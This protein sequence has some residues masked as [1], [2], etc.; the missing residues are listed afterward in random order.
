[1]G[2]S[3]ARVSSSAIHIFLERLALCTNSLIVD[4]LSEVVCECGK[5]AKGRGWIGG[6]WV[7]WKGGRCRVSGALWTEMEAVP[8]ECTGELAVLL[9]CLSFNCS[10]L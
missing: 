9:G 3:E 6:M 1:M 7:V 10:L 8:I 5:L 2:G 4:L